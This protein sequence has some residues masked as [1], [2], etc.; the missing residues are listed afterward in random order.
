MSEC[1]DL[2]HVALITICVIILGE[3][4]V[5]MKKFYPSWV[6]N[7]FEEPLARFL[8]VV[9]IYFVACVSPII[10][11]LLALIVVFIHI[12]YINLARKRIA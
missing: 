2:P 7:I 3:Y 8:S 5:D 6:I 12:D 4:G 9:V 1:I 10:A 11:T